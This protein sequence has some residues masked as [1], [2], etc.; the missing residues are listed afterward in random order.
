MERF[1][2]TWFT[3]YDL[4]PT[5]L[6]GAREN[7][8]PA[9]VADRVRFVRHDAAEGL[10]DTFEVITS[11]D[12]AGWS[13]AYCLTTALAEGGEGLGTCGL[14]ESEVR[15]AWPRPA[16]A[17]WRSSPS[18]TPS[19]CSTRPRP[20]T[21]SRPGPSRRH[22]GTGPRRGR[23]RVGATVGPQAGGPRP[24]PAR[25]LVGDVA[26]LLDSTLTIIPGGGRRRVRPVHQRPGLDLLRRGDV[27]AEAPSPRTPTRTTPSMTN[28]GDA[29]TGDTAGA[30]QCLLPTGRAATRPAVMTVASL[31]L[32]DGEA[33]LTGRA[34]SE[35]PHRARPRRNRLVSRGL[36]EHRG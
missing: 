25:T 4:S 23:G 26:C 10:D 30:V 13:L 29:R 36:R 15:A 12:V 17:R 24:R 22:R 5:Q 6:G 1:A 16:S 14:P 19:T 33:L 3:N 32:A 9:G 11:L 21:A 34:A 8:A 31:H 7:A 28:G 27:Y 35:H 2:D 18:T 20:E